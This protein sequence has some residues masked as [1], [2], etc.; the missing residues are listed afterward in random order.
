MQDWHAAINDSPKL[1]YYAM[2][3]EKFEFESY[4]DDIRNDNL[5]IYLTRFRISAH[6]LAIELGRYN[7]TER[8]NRLCIFCNQNCIESE[9]HVLLVCQKYKDIRSKYLK[10]CSWPSVNKFK[11]YYHRKTKEY[12]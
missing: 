8:D 7:N 5:R 6:S 1:K 9:Y 4:L 12:N 10:G 2:F 11:I 3:K